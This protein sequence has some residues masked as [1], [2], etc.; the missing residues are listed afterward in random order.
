M[1]IFLFFIFWISNFNN[2]VDEIMLIINIIKFT[3]IVDYTVVAVT[4]AY[5]IINLILSGVYDFDFFNVILL[6]I[7]GK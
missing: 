5:L 7:I 2:G 3:K 4:V 6:S 1:I